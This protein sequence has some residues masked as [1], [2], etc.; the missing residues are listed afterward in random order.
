MFI[1][2]GAIKNFLGTGQNVIKLGQ[3]RVWDPVN[4]KQ[5]LVS[6]LF[7][8]LC[9]PVGDMDQIS[10]IVNEAFLKY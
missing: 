7:L 5:K 9:W 4:F 3:I 1:D 8:S 2:L 6:I 10:S